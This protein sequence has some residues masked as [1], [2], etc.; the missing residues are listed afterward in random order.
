[1]P[2]GK[3]VFLPCK[4]LETKTLN[5]DAATELNRKSHLLYYVVINACCVCDDGS[6]CFRLGIAFLLNLTGCRYFYV[7]FFRLRFTIIE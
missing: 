5:V 3:S 1:M 4:G 7:V 6:Q 2:Y